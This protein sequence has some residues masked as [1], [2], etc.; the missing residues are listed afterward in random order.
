[1]VPTHSVFVIPNVVLVRMLLIPQ[2]D[3]FTRAYELVNP[4]GFG[5]KIGLAKLLYFVRDV[6]IR[7]FLGS[8]VNLFM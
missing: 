7:I 2:T 1:M 5:P 6:R 3:V 8:S 4:R